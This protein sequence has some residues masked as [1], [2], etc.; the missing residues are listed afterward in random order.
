MLVM[1]EAARAARLGEIRAFL[2]GRPETAHG[3]FTR[4]MLTCVLP[5]LRHLVQQ[6]AGQ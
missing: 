2:A 1:P 3:E 5:V 4:P 6:V